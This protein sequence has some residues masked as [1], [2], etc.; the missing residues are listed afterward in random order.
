MWCKDLHC[1][2]CGTTR[3]LLGQKVLFPHWKRVHSFE[4]LF[5]EAG[6][7]FIKLLYLRHLAIIRSN[8]GF[9][10]ILVVVY[11]LNPFWVS[12]FLSH[13]IL[14]VWFLG[15]EGYKGIIWKEDKK[16]REEAK[17]SL[18]FDF[19]AGFNNHSVGVEIFPESKWNVCVSETRC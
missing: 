10:A 5:V 19:I 16:R 13:V 14:L 9:Q 17:T 12:L 8:M 7:R 11:Y 2:V 18:Y 6:M 15:Y 1:I 4:L 3:C